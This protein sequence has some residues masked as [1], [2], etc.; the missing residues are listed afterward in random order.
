MKTKLTVT[1]IKRAALLVPLSTLHPQ[2]K[3][4]TMKTKYLFPL[5]F[6]ILHSAFCLSLRAQTTAF[7]YQGRLNDGEN[8]ANGK[9]DLTFALFSVVSGPAQVGNTLTNSTTGVSNGLFTVTLDFGNQFPGA[10]RWLEIGVRTNGNSAFTNLMPRQKLT[11][12]P[13][14]VYAGTVN[15]AGI[16]GQIADNQLSDNIAR[17]NADLRFTGPVQFAIMNSPYGLRVTSSGIVGGFTNNYLTGS[18]NVIAGGGTGGPRGTNAIS[19]SG[20]SAIGGGDGNQIISSGTSVISGGEQ[21]AVVSSGTS[22]IGSGNANTISNSVESFIGG[23]CV[24]QIFWSKSSGIASGWG[25]TIQGE[26]SDQSAWHFIG[27]G[28][29]NVI[30]LGE[31]DAISGGGGNSI[32]N[33]IYS[34]I[35]GGVGNSIQTHTATIGGGSGNEIQLNA[36]AGTIGGGSGNEIQPNARFATIPGGHLNSATNYAFAAGRRAKA[37]H[38]GAFVWAD[39]TDADFASTANNQFL[40]RASGGVGINLDNPSAALDVNGTVNA[41]GLISAPAGVR[42]DRTNV[43]FT[44]DQNHGVGW[45]G[46]GRSFAFAA[47]DGPVLFGFNGGALGTKQSGTERMALFWNN[48]GNVGI[49]TVSPDRPLAVQANG[50]SELMSLKDNTGANRWHLNLQSGGL[51]FAQS[52]VADGR[53]FLGT[54]GNVGIGTLIPSTKLEV[55][56]TVTA[57]AFNPPSDRNLKENF[58]PVSPREVLAKVAVMPISRWN[59][60]GDA[61]T[62]HVGP[63][64]QDFHAAFGLG[65]DDKHIATVDADGVALAAIQGLNEK[66]EVGSQR[67]EDRSR[68]LED[69]LQQKETEITELSQTVN[70]LK[71]LVQTMNHQI[72]G[73]AK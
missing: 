65:T 23:G 17:L 18:A 63:M 26:F 38:T 47:P 3:P 62:P 57:T 56:G 59:F 36:N 19:A 72:N 67:S 1:L 39:S 20:S 46:I 54:N 71:K 73:G 48:V 45:Y 10:D 40:I 15:A 32:T 44:G 68:K 37:I 14:A 9:Y 70:E 30:T 6:I 50:S 43:W 24:N 53:L 61:A 34:T 33:A 58:A 13:Y 5:C 55:I 41:S 2:L 7:T 52:A 60:I 16:A 42:V 12:A 21:H 64:A 28:V 11:A 25:N 66:V 8:P 27:G 35:G 22:G 51:N 69:R 29:G 49:G 31:Y 4:S